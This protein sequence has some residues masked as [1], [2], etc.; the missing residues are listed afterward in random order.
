MEVDTLVHVFRTFRR[1]YSLANPQLLTFSLSN[2]V[3][4]FLFL[5]PLSLCSGVRPLFSLMKIALRYSILIYRRVVSRKLSA[6]SH[7]HHH[8]RISRI[9]LYV[10]TYWI[11]WFISM[12]VCVCARAPLKITLLDFVNRTN[13]VIFP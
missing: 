9:D 6:K 2:F 11:R 5:F 13:M 1:F 12:N 10:L 4:L 7:H 8:H 3:F